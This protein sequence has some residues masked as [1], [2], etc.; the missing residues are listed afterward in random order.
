MDDGQT[1]DIV[2]Q[3]TNPDL[4]PNRVPIRKR[5]DLADDLCIEI[6][7]ADIVQKI[8]KACE[9]KGADFDPYRQLNQ[10]YS[11]VRE[12]PPNG[13]DLSWDNDQ[14]LQ[15]CIALSRLIHPTSISTEYAARIFLTSEGNL[16]KIVP[17]PIASNSSQAFVIDTSLNCFTEIDA[18]NLKRVIEAFDKKPL[19][20][21]LARAMWY[22]EYAARS[23]EIDLKWVLIATGIEVI[24]HIDRYKSTRQFVKIVQKLS[25]DV[26]AGTITKNQAE[27]MYEFRSSLAHGQGLGGITS[28]KKELYG[29]MEDVLRLTIQKSILEESFRDFISNPDEIRKAWP[30]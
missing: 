11:F 14:R 28:E 12:N 5:I 4:D 17:G 16:K 10:M 15:R 19:E 6:F 1:F 23:Y 9:P 8:F 22:H 24:V 2:V 7:R 26:G 3:V 27:E 13:D 29:K 25:I 21:P 30:V 20:D 18:Q